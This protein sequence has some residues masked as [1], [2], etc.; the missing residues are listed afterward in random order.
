MDH[1]LCVNSNAWNVV[2]DMLGNRY[3]C[4][5]H[6]TLDSKLIQRIR[7]RDGS[8]SYL[9]V[10]TNL[11][12]SIKA[13]V[14]DGLTPSAEAA[15]QLVNRAVMSRRV[16]GDSIDA[17]AAIRK[18]D[19]GFQAPILVYTGAGIIDHAL[20]ALADCFVEHTSQAGKDAD[21]IG[22]RI[23]TELRHL[24]ARMK[25]SHLRAR[26][27]SIA[28]DNGYT[29]LYSAMNVRGGLDF[30]AA[31]NLA[32][33]CI[34]FKGT[35]WCDEFPC[36]DQEGKPRRYDCTDALQLYRVRAWHPVRVE[37]KGDDSAAERLARTFQKAFKGVR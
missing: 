10:I 11:P 34:S 13:G 15:Q 25:D 18:D 6:P 16:Y 19:V 35:V 27:S 29:R 37:I 12:F 8:D 22:E 17:L 5:D 14:F 28:V 31:S 21:I 30:G 7:E 26:N 1:L 4:D 36:A 23:E 3:A 2:R 32:R 33:D 9:A 24:P 20:F